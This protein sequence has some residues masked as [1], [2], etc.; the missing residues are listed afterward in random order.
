MKA[1]AVSQRPPPPIHTPHPD[2][3]AGLLGQT[4]I[5]GKGYAVIALRDIPA[6]TVLENTPVIVVDQQQLF[7]PDG[8]RSPLL[9][10]AFWWGD[11]TDDPRPLE[12]AIVKGGF[13]ALANHDPDG[14]NSTIEQ[15]RP[16]M[17]ITWSAL[18]DIRAGEEITFDYDCDLWFD[19]KR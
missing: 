15:N 12:Y 13:L 2:F 19:P 14:G 18:E 5:D 1:A 17:T 4:F 9:D 3:T 16:A 11:L 10:Y 6:G 8:T 7:R